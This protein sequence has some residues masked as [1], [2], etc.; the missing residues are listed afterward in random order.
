M[1]DVAAQPFINYGASIAD[2]QSQLAGA[3]L[4][5]ARTQG[6]EIQNQQNAMSLELQQ[7]AMPLYRQTIDDMMSDG[8]GVANSNT[9]TG[10]GQ[11]GQPGAQSSDQ[12]GEPGAPQTPFYADSG[13]IAERTRNASWVEPITQDESRRIRQGAIMAASPGGNTMFLEQAKLQHDY[14][15]QMQTNA[16]QYRAGQ[17]YDTLTA[18]ADPDNKDPLGMLGA[19]P[20]QGQVAAQ[21]RRDHPGDDAGAQDAARKYAQMAAFHTHQYMYPDNQTEMQNGVLIDKKKGQPV[22][23]QDQ[24]LNGMTPA[25]RDKFLQ[26]QNEPIDVKLTGGGTIKMA[27]WRAPVEQGGGGGITPTAALSREDALTRRRLNGGDTTPAGAGSWNAPSAIGNTNKTPSAADAAA[28]VAPLPPGQ[29]PATGASLQRLKTNPPIAPADITGPAPPSGTPA[30]EQR[31]SAAL[32]D[33]QYKARFAPANF[34]NIPG[35]PV[36]GAEEGVKKYIGDQAELRTYGGQVSQTAATSL[37]NLHAAKEILSRDAAL[38]IT[39]PLGAIS[40]KLAALGYNTDTAT[41]RQEA[42]KYLT[43]F[44]VSSLKDTYGSRPAAF[45]VKINLEQAFPNVKEMGTTAINDL[46]DSQIKQAQY[47]KETGDRA[48]RYANGRSLEPGSFPTWNERYFPKEDILASK[49][50]GPPEGAETKPY[51][52]KNYYLKPGADRSKQENWI[53]Y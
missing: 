7:R 34:A 44:A 47:L 16:A 49:T 42:A 17:T 51:Q 46:V 4:T 50:K 22:T 20:G 8:S 38:P 41:G 13:A 14:R 25:E 39:G 26:W 28:A 45:D 11:P 52:G 37:M 43:N 40:Q 21:I 31:V 18:V 35:A 48:Q 5:R 23:G 10:A 12:S 19:L 33:P 15:V 24:V 2:Q 27:R 32:R 29:K 36:P 6:V 1:A 9:P 3:D 30:Y 53:A